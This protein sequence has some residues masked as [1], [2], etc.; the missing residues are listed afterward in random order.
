MFTEGFSSAIRGGRADDPATTDVDESDS[1]DPDE[2]VLNFRGIPEGVTVTASLMGTGEA[3]EDDGTD[4]APLMLKTGDDEGAD[5]DGVVSLSSIGNGE[6]V[7][8]FDN[9]TY[10]HD[11]DG[12]DMDV[13]AQNGEGG[14]TAPIP[15]V[16]DGTRQNGITV[17]ITFTWKAGE[18]P[19]DMGTVTVSYES[20]GRWHW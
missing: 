7:Y 20:R 10:D 12:A 16:D 1:D 14:M 3:M 13:E 6:I 11:D 9:S 19:L 17:E 8:T 2:L 15:H 18:P 4:L 5:K